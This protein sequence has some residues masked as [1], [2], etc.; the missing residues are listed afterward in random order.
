MY[1]AML[2]CGSTSTADASTLRLCMSGGAAMPAELMRSFERRF[3]C[4]ILEGYG[5]GDL[6]GRLLQP[7]QPRAQAVPRSAPRSRA[8]R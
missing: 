5:L 2:H 6:A 1:N 3:D 4:V 7:P 8:W